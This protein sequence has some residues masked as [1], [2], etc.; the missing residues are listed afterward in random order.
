MGTE[1]YHESRTSDIYGSTITMVVAATIAVALRL[2]ARRLSVA[3]FWWDDW[4]LVLALV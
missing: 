1:A 2:Y 3:K 4:M